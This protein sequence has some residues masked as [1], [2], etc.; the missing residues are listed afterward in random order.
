MIDDKEIEKTEE[1]KK[2]AVLPEVKNTEPALIAENSFE[3]I[4]DDDDA[5][6]LEKKGGDV[7]EELP[8]EIKKKLEARKEEKAPRSR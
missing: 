8:D 6:L 2:E 5:K 4:E 3:D 1:V 7:T